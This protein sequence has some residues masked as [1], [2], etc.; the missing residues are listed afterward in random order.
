MSNS[1]IN[2]V[3]DAD[4]LIKDIFGSDKN[5]NDLAIGVQNNTSSEINIDY[6]IDH[7]SLK[8]IKSPD[9]N[10]ISPGQLW[11]A[12]V[13]AKGAGSNIGLKIETSTISFAVIAATPPNKQNYVKL[14]HNETGY[15]SGKQA[16]K[17]A[18][19]NGKHYSDEGYLNRTY[20]NKNIVINITGESPAACSIIVSDAE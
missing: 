14:S 13:I 12:G 5:R 20:G 15:V 10:K 8:K 16:W 19:G 11:E 3:I 6:Y 1:I 9:A 7:G 17:A 2:D 18:N 4:K